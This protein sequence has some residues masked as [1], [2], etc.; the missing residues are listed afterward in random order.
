M[1]RIWVCFFIFSAL[2]LAQVA[3][4]FQESIRASMQ[5]SLDKQKSSVQKQAASA[6]KS[7]VASTTSPG[8]AFYTVP[9]PSPVQPVAAASGS[10]DCEP[11]AKEELDE[12]VKTASAKEGVNPDLVRLMIGKESASKPCA[13][14]PKGA[15]GLMQLM[16][17]TADELGVLDPL[18]PRQNVEG[19]TRLLKRLLTK[20]NGDVALALGAYN[21][22][23]GRV[24]RAGGVPQIP[25][26]MN[27]VSDIMSRFR[28][29]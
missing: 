29:E 15:Q 7:S 8:S 2:G 4:D 12:V 11:M 1:I 28:F 25:E 23:S 20:Y 24:D 27:Y 22:G 19:G 3:S 14:S 21:A 13:V 10:M 26:T 16:P 9:W 18:D 6:V 5:A 17:A